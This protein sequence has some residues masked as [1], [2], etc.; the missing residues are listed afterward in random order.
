MARPRTFDEQDVVAA[1][2]DQFW[3]AGYAGTS[4]EDLTEATGLGRGSLYGAFGDKHD[5]YLRA[6][7]DYCAG[8]LASV[9]DDLTNPTVTAYAR[10]VGHLGKVADATAEA[11]A[12]GCLLAKS[13]DELGSSDEDVARRVS[14]TMK[15]YQRLLKDTVAQ[16]QR[17]GDLD[18]DV[19]PD[20]LALLALTFIR[21]AEALGKSGYGQ[22][23]RMAA[24]EQFV[25]LLPRPR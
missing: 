10:L 20:R 15:T 3:T 12:R 5:L 21:G 8:T 4:V 25:A 18:P 13:A 2:R 11:A 22:A 6:L 24:A 14:D 23:R 9:A 19:D 1:A 16:A 7:D 17:E